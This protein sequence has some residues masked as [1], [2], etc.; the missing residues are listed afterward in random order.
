VHSNLTPCQGTVTSV[1]HFSGKFMVASRP[2]GTLE[3]EQT[4]VRIETDSGQRV[5]CVQGAG[6]VARRI[7]TWLK[8]GE[9]VAR[10]EGY[11][12]IRFG[13]R[14]DVYLPVATEIKV[15]VG[16][17]IRGGESVIGVFS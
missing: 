15:K 14:M 4:A 1:A 2:G 10:G 5:L 9:R 11:G 3:N 6:C 7:V 16:D 13:S 12:L 8:P 17:C